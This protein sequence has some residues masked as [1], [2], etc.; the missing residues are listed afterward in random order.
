MDACK[1]NSFE[2]KYFP[3]F[4]SYISSTSFKCCAFN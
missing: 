1:L 2:E 4:I 3:T